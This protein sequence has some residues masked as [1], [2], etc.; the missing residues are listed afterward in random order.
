MSSRREPAS[1]ADGLVAV[2][3]FLTP[4]Q[5]DAIRAELSFAHWYPSA[6]VGG[7][8]GPR[9]SSSRVSETTDESWFTPQLSRSLRRLD[10]RIAAFFPAFVERR[11]EWQATRY[12]RGGGFRAHF[13]CG[14]WHDEPAGEREHSMVVFLDTPR[15]GGETC[16]PLLGVA[17]RP[18]AGLL[19]A[20]R[21]LAAGG[22]RD[23]LMIHSSLPVRAGRKTILVTWLRQ[24]VYERRVR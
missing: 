4:E 18:K 13:D 12:F 6:V 3:D 15:A 24:R 10:R 7:G 20:W 14:H 17:I 11:E 23:P 8:L 2:S 21:N 16:F 22:G 1:V 5:C 19:L 9:I